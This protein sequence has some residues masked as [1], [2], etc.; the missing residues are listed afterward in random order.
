MASCR[1]KNLVGI[2]VL[3]DVSSM[4]TG[5][6]WSLPLVF[7]TL[8]CLAMERHRNHHKHHKH[9]HNPEQQL[10]RIPSMLQDMDPV[11]P[12]KHSFDSKSSA[13]DQSLKKTFWS[14][15][16]FFRQF[17]FTLFI[18]VMHSN[19]CKVTEVMRLLHTQTYWGTC[20]Y[21]LQCISTYI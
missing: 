4:K 11:T 14:V 19:N 6:C 12:R 21:Y 15:L 5:L 1:Q 8:C 17:Y 18:M 10:E 13:A 3:A 2:I 7:S 20:M 16:V 9:H